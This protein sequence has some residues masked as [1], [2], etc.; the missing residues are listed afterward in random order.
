[1]AAGEKLR[2]IIM[3]SDDTHVK[4]LDLLQRNNY[5]GADHDQLRI[6]RQQ[7]VP[8][9]TD[10]EAHMSLHPHPQDA[11]TR[12]LTKPH[13]HGDVHQVLDASQFPT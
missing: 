8:A 5:F 3:T 12:V 13:G 10:A 1:M 7:Q 4:T 2:L 11:S 9:L 6:V